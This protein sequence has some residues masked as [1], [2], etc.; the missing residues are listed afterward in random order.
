MGFIDKFGLVLL[1]VG[2]LAIIAFLR[3]FGLLKGKNFIYALSAGAM[4]FGITALQTW[5]RNRAKNDFDRR[6]DDLKKKEKIVADLKELV[7]LSD[8]EKY[9]TDAALKSERGA[10]AMKVANIDAEKEKDIQEAKEKNSDMS[11]DEL[12]ASILGS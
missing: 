4:F 12:T 9:R 3:Q 7:N 6:E 8:K 11:I 5:R 10:H 1:A 2:I